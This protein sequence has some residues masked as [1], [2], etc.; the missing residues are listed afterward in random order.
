VVA[1]VVVDVYA[2]VDADVGVGGG[3]E[4]VIRRLVDDNIGYDDD[5]W[6]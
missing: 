3:A 6:G 5:A 1:E 4:D 2:G